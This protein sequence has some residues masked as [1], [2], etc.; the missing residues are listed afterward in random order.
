MKTTTTQTALAFGDKDRNAPLVSAEAIRLCAYRKW[1]SAGKPTGDGI[2][3]WLEAEQEVAQ[4]KQ[5]VGYR[6]TF[7]LASLKRRIQMRF[8]GILSLA[9]SGAVLSLGCG[10]DTSPT[11]AAGSKISS[12]KEKI[13]D[14]ADATTEA[15][16]AKR[17]E[18]VREMQKQLDKLDAKYEELKASAAKAEGQSKKDLEKKVEAA[19]VKRDAAAKKLEEL[20]AAG[21]DRWEKVKE[22]VGNA[23]D[24]LKKMFE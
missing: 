23:F 19:K 3:F 12:A 13:K 20:K 18:Y 24:D 4:G 5:A 9:L 21:A 7:T 22:S 2:R 8:A 16:K 15:A 11:P 17:D 6:R 1:E 14:A 10:T